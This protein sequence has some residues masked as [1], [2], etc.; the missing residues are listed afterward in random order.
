MS[1]SLT[2]NGEFKPLDERNTEIFLDVV[3]QDYKLDQMF[4]S[5]YFS[6][7]FCAVSKLKAAFSLTENVSMVQTALLLLPVTIHKANGL[8]LSCCFTEIYTL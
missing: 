3:E 4:S 2:V 1:S 5:L 8:M 6:P 7:A